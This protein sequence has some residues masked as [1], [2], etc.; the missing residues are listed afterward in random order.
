MSSARSSR[1]VAAE[2]AGQRHEQAEPAERVVAA[3]RAEQPQR[4]LEPARGDR[5]R[6]RG[7]LVAG[8]LEHRRRLVVAD[9][10]RLLD[11]VGARGQRARP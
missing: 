1:P 4:G 11:V 2:R 10:G 8:L 5:G 3:L 7:G 6:A 9:A